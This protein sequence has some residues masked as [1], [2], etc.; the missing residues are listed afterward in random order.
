MEEGKAGDEVVLDSQEM[1]FGD[2]AIRRGFIRKVYV[3]LSMQVSD[4][5]HQLL[6]LVHLSLLM[7]DIPLSSLPSPWLQLLSSSSTSRPT[8]APTRRT[9][10][11]LIDSTFT[12][13]IQHMTT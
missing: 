1:K 13:T 4:Q 10:S 7:S 5:D 6:C 3:I 12:F 8:S 9:W 11:W 2:K